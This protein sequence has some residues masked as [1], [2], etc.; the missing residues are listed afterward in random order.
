MVI[1]W[2]ESMK[3]RPAASAESVHA[4]VSGVA[5]TSLDWVMSS[6]SSASRMLTPFTT[7]S[8]PENGSKPYGRRYSR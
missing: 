5:S 2:A 8:V 4:V 7:G 6:Q 3:V 1:P